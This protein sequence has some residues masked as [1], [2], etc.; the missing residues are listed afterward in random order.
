LFSDVVA[1][2]LEQVSDDTR[3]YLEIQC[4]MERHRP[5]TVN[6]SDYC[7]LTA[8]FRANLE[9]R[10]NRQERSTGP[11]SIT[12]TIKDDS[13]NS[14][15]VSSKVA[16][17]DRF[18]GASVSTPYF[19]STPT[20]PDPGEPSKYK[21]ELELMS[22]VLAYHVIS[23]KRIS[24]VVP[25]IF[26]TVFACSFSDRL[27]EILTSRL[28]LVGESGLE[29]CARYAQDEPDIELKR[30]KFKKQLE[31]LFDALKILHG[32]FNSK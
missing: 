32:F 1:E 3:K 9:D 28:K 22:Q 18:M 4:K 24:D 21:D 19:G 8:A 17:F 30:N 6:Y 31:V 15:T 11:V 14:R 25:M 23:S 16:N 12:Y 13:G 7:D 5:F 2:V 26:E 29:N 20:P 10:R 27:R